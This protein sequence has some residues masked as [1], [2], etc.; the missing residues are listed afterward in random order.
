MK[1]TLTHSRTQSAW[2]VWVECEI[3]IK[4]MMD[5]K[6]LMKSRDASCVSHLTQY[7]TEIE[8]SKHQNVFPLSQMIL[9]PLESYVTVDLIHQKR[10]VGVLVTTEL[11][12]RKAENDWLK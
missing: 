9:V 8:Y 4:M 6:G 10:F 1:A 11:W 3:P 12:K 7:C 2:L 5:E